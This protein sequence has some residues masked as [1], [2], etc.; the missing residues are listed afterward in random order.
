MPQLLALV[1]LTAACASVPSPK[2]GERVY[3][4]L[5]LRQA[6][7][8]VAKPKLLGETGRVVRAERRQ[9]GNDVS[10]Y[11]LVLTPTQPAKDGPFELEV[12][13]ELPQ[14]RGHSKLSLLHGEERRLDLGAKPGDLEMTL[15]LMR[16]DSPE[17][18]SLMRLREPPSG[19]GATDWTI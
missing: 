9:P 15:L 11:R 10:D 3:L 19:G 17:F 4:A 16:V 8:L 6:G 2:V 1:F 18:R 14:A 7:R 12:S 5:E 13:L